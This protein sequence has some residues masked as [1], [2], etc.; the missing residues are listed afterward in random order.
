MQRRGCGKSIHTE[1]ETTTISDKRHNAGNLND[2]LLLKNCTLIYIA[3]IPLSDSLKIILARRLTPQN[4]DFS[5]S[6]Q[7]S[8][9]FT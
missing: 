9:I 1:H 2:G 4:I 8:S 6:F 7:K 5:S 3:L